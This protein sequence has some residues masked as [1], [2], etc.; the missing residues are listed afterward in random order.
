MLGTVGLLPVFTDIRSVTS[1]RFS[2]MDLGQVS[3][4]FMKGLF[5]SV[6]VSLE[7][8]TEAMAS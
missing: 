1:L 2:V 4:G 5:L 6:A 8:R 7:D 3:F